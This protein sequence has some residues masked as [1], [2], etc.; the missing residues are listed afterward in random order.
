LADN[1]K[2]IGFKDIKNELTNDEKILESAFKFETLYKKHKLKLWSVIILTVGLFGGMAVMDKIHS[3][4]LIEANEAFL[5]LQS[6]SQD[7]KALDTLKKN[8]FALYELYRL[9]LAVKNKDVEILQ[10]LSHSKNSVVADIST[11]S[12]SVLALNPNEDT[13]IYPEMALFEGA[14]LD[15]KKGKNKEAKNKLELIDE[16]SSFGQM[17]KFLRHATVKVN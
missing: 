5:V 17:A 11:Y 4:K 6:N 8:N 2:T 15:I 13:K 12:E 16:Q 10:S 9:N 14:Y 7:N 3:D 1:D